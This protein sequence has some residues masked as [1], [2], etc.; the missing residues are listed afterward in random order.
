[1]ALR[2]VDFRGVGNTWVGQA[3]GVEG[4]FFTTRLVEVLKS[5][6]EQ[7]AIGGNAQACVMMKAP[8]AM[9]LKRPRCG[10]PPRSQARNPFRLTVSSA[11]IS[12]K[13]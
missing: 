7:E 2:P 8:S 6:R 4:S 10:P 11:H 1:M 5:L 3:L 9:H 12:A 13:G